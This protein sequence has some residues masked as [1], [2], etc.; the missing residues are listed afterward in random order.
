MVVQNFRYPLAGLQDAGDNPKNGATGAEF[1]RAFW[2][3][4]GAVAQRRLAG[5]AEGL[6]GALPRTPTAS[7]I[8]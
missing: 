3:V 7:L 6:W 4:A 5:V 2:L 8:R 1:L